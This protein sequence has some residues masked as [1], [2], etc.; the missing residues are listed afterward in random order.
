MHAAADAATR[1]R[2]VSP[3]LLSRSKMPLTWVTVYCNGMLEV[4]VKAPCQGWGA[5]CRE[6]GQQGEMVRVMQGPLQL[7]LP[8]THAAAV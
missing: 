1:C 2:Q 5:A 7:V 6:R 8:D 4:T 3:T